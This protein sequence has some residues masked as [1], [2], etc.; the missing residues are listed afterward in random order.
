MAGSALLASN[1]TAGAQAAPKPQHVFI[2]VLENEGF[3]RTFGP[4]S[5]ALYLKQ[6]AANAGLLTNYYGVGHNSLDNYIAMISGQAPNPLTQQ[7]CPNSNRRARRRMARRSEPAAS[8]ER[9]SRPWSIS[10]R[11]PRD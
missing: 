1:L 5:P 4:Y 8:S 7:D 11:R 10:L 9:A 2:I 6:L 3:D